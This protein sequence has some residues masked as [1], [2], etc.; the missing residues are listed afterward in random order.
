MPPVSRCCP[1]PDASVC[2]I[3]PSSDVAVG[4]APRFL[5]PDRTSSMCFPNVAAH[6]RSAN[7]DSGCGRPERQSGTVAISDSS[8]VEPGGDFASPVLSG[9]ESPCSDVLLHSIV[10]ARLCEISPMFQGKKRQKTHFFNGRHVIADVERPVSRETQ[11]HSAQTPAQ[12]FIIVGYFPSR[13]RTIKFTRD[14]IMID[15]GQP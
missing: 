9:N 15:P 3:R 10:Y 2:P 8:A 11:F 6:R 4:C 13:P 1:S 12:R 7:W 5:S 14:R